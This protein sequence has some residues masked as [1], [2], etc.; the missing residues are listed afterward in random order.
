M[1]AYWR[2]EE[3]YLAPAYL[4]DELEARVCALMPRDRHAG[5]EGRYQIRSIYFD[6]GDDTCYRENEAGI[7]P[8]EK[9]RLRAYDCAASPL[10]LELK[11]RRSGM[12]HKETATV[13]EA[14]CRTIMAGRIP[15]LTDAMPPLAARLVGAMQCRDLHPVCVV[16][17]DRDPFVWEDGNVRITFDRNIRSA[18]SVASFFA[19]D[20]AAR[21]VLPDGWHILEV[22]WDGF[23]PSFLSG[24][25]QTGLL[26]RTSFSKYYFCRR[27]QMNGIMP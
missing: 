1:A 9:F 15:P 6:D 8:R 24:I 10:H 25:L 13:D 12:C 16:V 3:K 22:K 14:F 21:P 27:Y 18:A 23:L 4:L 26:R 11:M 17:Y 2:H 5:A 19:P 7:D 20:L